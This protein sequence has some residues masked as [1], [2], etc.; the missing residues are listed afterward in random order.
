MRLKYL[1]LACTLAATPAAASD[2]ADSIKADYD[3]RLGAMFV[4]FHRN[5]ELSFKENRTAKIIAKALRA[6]GATVTEGVGGTGVVGIMRNGAGPTVLV[7]ADMDALPVEEK[8]GLPY[9]SHVRQAGIDGVEW[10]VA[11]ACGHDVHITSLI[12]TAHQLAAMK[13]RWRGTVVLIAQPAEERVG[14]AKA[15]LADGLYTR[16]PKPDYAL[17]FHVNSGMRT[18]TVSGADA[19]M[20]SSA[21]SVDITVHGIGAHGASPQSGKDPVYIGAQLVTALQSIV[22][23]EVGPLSP[24]VITVGS[25]H[26]GTKHNIISDRADLQITVRANDEAVRHQ[27]LAAIDR[28]AKNI[29]RANGVAENQLP[30]VRSRK[31]RRPPATRPPSPVGSAPPGPRRCPP[32]PS[33]R[34]PRRAWGRRTSPIS[35]S[36]NWACRASISRSA[37]RRRRRSTPPGRAGRRCRRT[38]RPCSRSIRSRRCGSAPRR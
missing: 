5:P 26:A 17:G 37:A 16:F 4:D 13:D 1:L 7:R 20:Y 24:A 23:R 34:S 2:F 21:D 6:E 22:S 15:M 28:M 31:G 38:I 8:S 10:P 3:K 11:H 19:L 27:L 35:S 29:A 12:G 36:P 9:A 18:G 25:F 14:G 32:A 33:S 30:D